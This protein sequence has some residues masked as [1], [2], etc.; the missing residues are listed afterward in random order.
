MRRLCILAAA[1][2]AACNDIE[3]PKPPELGVEIEA[4][5]TSVVAGTTIEF[6][7]VA[8]GDK[9]EL[10]VLDFGDGLQTSITVSNALFVQQTRVHAFNGAGSYLV[11][12]TA[13]EAL[14]ATASDTI[15]IDVAEPGA[16]R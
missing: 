4:S 10:I 9:L 3:G 5:E 6:S 1:L 7:V 14:G 13:Q 8:R 12:A 16:A 11:T 2:L 15:R